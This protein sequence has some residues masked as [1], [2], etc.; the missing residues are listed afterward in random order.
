MTVGLEVLVHDVIAAIATDPDPDVACRPSISTDDAATLSAER[1]A[2]RSGPSGLGRRRSRRTGPGGNGVDRRRPRVERSSWSGAAERSSP[3]G[4]FAGSCPEPVSGTRS[5]GR[6]GPATDGATVARSSSSSASNVRP[7]ARLA[8][9]ALRLGV[10]LDEVDELGRPAGQAQVGRA[11][12]RRWG[13]ASTVA[14]N[15]GLMLRDRR[16]VRERQ[17]RQPVARRTR[18]TRRRPRTRAASRS[19]RARGRSRSSRAA[20]RRVRR[21]PTIRGIGW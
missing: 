8:P 15:S 11:S 12:R 13:R 1:R 16:P 2:A 6:R 10:A 21:T 18:R 14:P 17:A 3:S 7:G 4:K 9:Q 20:A 5:C 19:R